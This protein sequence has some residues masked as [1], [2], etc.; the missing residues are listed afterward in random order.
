MEQSNEAHARR[1]ILHKI[2]LG[3]S[4]MGSRGPATRRVQ[5]GRGACPCVSPPPPSSI[6]EDLLLFTVSVK[7]VAENVRQESWISYLDSY[8]SEGHASC[9]APPA[10]PRAIKSRYKVGLQLEMYRYYV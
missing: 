1:G 2:A 7:S 6:R 3:G 9:M 4:R 10:R 8:P 5:G